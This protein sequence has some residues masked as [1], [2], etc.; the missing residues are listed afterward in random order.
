MYDIDAIQDIAPFSMN[1]EEKEQFLSPILGELTLHHYQNCPEYRR[2][3]DAWPYDVH[4][5]RSYYNIPFLPVRLFKEFD[6][7]SIGSE[8]FTKEIVSSGTTG[9][10]VARIFLDKETATNQTRIL[11][12]IVND[13]LGNI[14]LP[15]IILDSSSILQDRN[16][17]SARGAGILGFSIFGSD[18]L[19]ALDEE[20]HLD[21]DALEVFLEKYRGKDIFLFG[22]TFMIW[23]HFYKELLASGRKLDLSRGILIHG[24]GWKKLTEEAVDNATYKQALEQLCGITKVYNFYGMVEQTGTI[25]MEC[26][27]GYLHA[28]V[29]ADVI[30]RDVKDFSVTPVGQEGLIEVVSIL[31]KSYPGHMLLTEDSGIIVGE[32]NCPCGRL[33]KYFLVLGRIKNAEIRGCGDTYA[34]KFE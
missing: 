5:L 34:T 4:T 22:F 28:P 8:E 6:L 29:F 12:M 23:Q 25:Y 11:T 32:D 2:L 16:L 17:F 1:K 26:E 31:P 9:Q 18:T 15:M 21:F 24:G 19:Y 33:G 3:M 10:Q 27:H 13:F 20:M 14:R 7:R 30:V